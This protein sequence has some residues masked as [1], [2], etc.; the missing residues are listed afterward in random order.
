MHLAVGPDGPYLPGRPAHRH[1]HAA[2]RDLWDEAVARLGGAAG[3]THLNDL[4]GAIPGA[5]AEAAAGR[6]ALT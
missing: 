6:A 4:L 1:V 2:L 5:I 3:C